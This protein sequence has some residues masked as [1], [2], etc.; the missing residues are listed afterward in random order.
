MPGFDIN[1]FVALDQSLAQHLCCSICLNIFNESINCECGHTFCK[2]CVREL[3][4]NRNKSCPECRQ[5]MVTRKRSHSQTNDN[6]RGLVVVNGYLFIRNIKINSIISELKI[7][8]DFEFNGCQQTP[9]LG[10][11]SDHL[12]TCE[13]RNCQTCGFTAGRAD[14]HNC[15]ELLKKDRDEWKLKYEKREQLIDEL[16]KR[17]SK[18]EK[19]DE[20]EDQSLDED[21]D[22]R[23]IGDAL[24]NR[25]RRMNRRVYAIRTAIYSSPEA[26]SAP[27]SSSDSDDNN[28]WRE[29]EF[30]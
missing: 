2:T 22:D 7:K 19:K 10:L 12:K 14:E 30:A 11:L 13:H 25:I 27:T 16:K 21:E 23:R 8:C 20:S 28:N 6:Q 29:L 1:R 5:I 3:I 15:L 4:D 17:V 18:H 24:Q 9:Q 26:S